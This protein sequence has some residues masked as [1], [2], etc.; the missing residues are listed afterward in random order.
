MTADMT[1]AMLETLAATV[2]SDDD[3]AAMTPDQALAACADMLY[4]GLVGRALAE[5]QADVDAWGVVMQRALS[6]VSSGFRV[7]LA[8]PPTSSTTPSEASDK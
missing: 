4:W 6:R 2:P 8:A 5:T 3:I 1:R 7:L